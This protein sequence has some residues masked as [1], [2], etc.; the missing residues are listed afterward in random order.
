MGVD[1]RMFVRVP[2]KLTKKEVFAEA[3]RIA[4]A[5]ASDTFFVRRPEKDKSGRNRGGRHALE[6]VE[7]YQQDGPDI[8]PEAGETLVEVHLWTRYYG[9]GYE[10]GDLVAILAVARWL[11][12]V[13][14]DGVV[15]YGGDSSGILAAPLDDDALWAHYMS[16][17]GRA[18]FRGHWDRQTL[19][20]SCDFCKIPLSSVNATKYYCMACRG[21][22][23]QQA[24]GSLRELD[25]QW[26]GH[27][28]D[29]PVG[30]LQQVL[31][32]L[33]AKEARVEDARVT[34]ASGGELSWFL[35]V[36]GKRPTPD[37]LENAGVAMLE[38]YRA[39]AS[40]GGS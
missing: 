40:G 31:A 24:D 18:Y 20:R 5:F 29:D 34:G 23:E 15:W 8:V 9:P 38:R 35:R 10:R 27:V 26:T 4:S 39:E 7:T 37:A 1:A 2:R 33:S 21:H 6:I 28:V 11:R 19:A 12:G 36:V 22:W 25:D 17:R 3:V 16:E 13:W 30:E 14:P 32:A